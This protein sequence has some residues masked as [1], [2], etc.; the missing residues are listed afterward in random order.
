MYK[1]AKSMNTYELI[2]EE[3]RNKKELKRI[4][5]EAYE[6]KINGLEIQLRNKKEIVRQHKRRVASDPGTTPLRR[7]RD[8]EFK[9]YSRLLREEEKEIKGLEKEIEAT[10]KE[11]DAEMKILDG[12][13]K[14]LE[15]NLKIY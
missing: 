9:L 3:I 10:R 2:Q 11:R 6:T 5:K 15:A 14:A 8:M 12:E 1:L 13:I 7:Q 4:K